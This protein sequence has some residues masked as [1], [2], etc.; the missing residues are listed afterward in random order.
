M[1][2]IR[3]VRHGTT[4]LNGQGYVATKMDLPLNENGVKMCMENKF[5]EGNFDTVYCSP[6]KRTVETAKL[7]YSY[8]QP[9]I[10][11]LISQRD[12]GVLNERFKSEFNIEYLEQVRNYI[13][14]PENSEVLEEII[15]RLNEFFEVIKSNNNTNSNILVVTHNG[16]MRIIKKEFMNT[17]TYED[18]NN[19]GGFCMK[20][21]KK[22]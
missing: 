15:R 2:N 11:P 5:K 3:F 13:I 1:I 14:N 12:M 8:K 20:L 4:N 19:L 18:S 9:I 6:Y 17:E 22:K 10:S 16:I 21:E 7:L